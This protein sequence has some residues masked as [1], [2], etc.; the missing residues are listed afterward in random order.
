MRGVFFAVLTQAVTLAAW[1]V[2]CMNNMKLCGTNGLTRF[3]KIA[4][5]ELTNQHVKLSLYLVTLAALAGTYVLCRRLVNSGFG[6][7]LIAIRDNESRLRFFGYEPYQFKV[8][9]FALSAMLADKIPR[10]AHD[11]TC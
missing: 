3:A 5:F 9:V 2:F 6:R 11:L 8:F 1:L 4:G 7:V 10:I